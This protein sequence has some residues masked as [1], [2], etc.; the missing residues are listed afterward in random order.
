VN[1]VPIFNTSIGQFRLV[2]FVL[3]G[4]LI[5]IYFPSCYFDMTQ[6]NVF[7]SKSLYLNPKFRFSE[8]QI[9]LM[10]YTGLGI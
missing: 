9:P 4:Q 5:Y 10:L 7:S 1:Q 3:S 6:K 2:V 8:N